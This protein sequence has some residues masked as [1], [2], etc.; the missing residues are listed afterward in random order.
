[1]GI[2]VS[3]RIAHVFRSLARLRLGV[4]FLIPSVLAC[5][6]AQAQAPN[7]AGQRIT[8]AVSTTTGGSYDFYARLVSRHIGRF[9][10]GGPSATVVNMP[11]AGGVIEANW[12]YNVAPKDGTAI[13]IVP[14]SAAF[15]GLLGGGGQAKYDAR[16]FGWLASLNEYIG[17]AVVWSQA[18]FERA[19][20]ILDREIIIGGGGSGS[21][22]TIW[23][24]LLNALIGAKIK[25]VTGYVGTA[26]VF[27]A[28][29]R[30][31]VQGMVGQDWDGVKTSKSDWLRD[32]KLRLLMQIALARAPDLP[33]VPTVMEFAKDP[34]DRQVL[35][36]FVG[37]QKYARPFAA[38]P[39]LPEPILAALRDAFAKMSV[40]REFLADAETSK[41]P[42]IFAPGPDVVKLA[43]TIYAAPPALIE[44]AIGELAAASK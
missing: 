31:E 18:P 7:F 9:L 14:L 3:T 30:G 24:R 41:L 34:A 26:N 19:Q 6:S 11:G 32:N 20:D 16:R 40:D 29:E 4:A 43:E 21:D 8:I 42:I 44:R 15:E 2:P 25:L 35:E 36:L 5:A 12:L 1:M 23:P 22:I 13:G 33:N 37:R 28:M 39:G 27:L 38:P 17:S 10:P